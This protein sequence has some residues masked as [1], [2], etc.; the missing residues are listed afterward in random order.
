[1]RRFLESIYKYNDKTIFRMNS[2]NLLIWFLCF[3]NSKWQADAN[4]ATDYLQNQV[5]QILVE[6]CASE[7]DRNRT[8]SAI[9]KLAK[10]YNPEESIKDVVQFYN[11]N[12]EDS[13]N[14]LLFFINQLDSHEKRHIAVNTLNDLIDTDQL[15]L[16]NVLRFENFIRE[17]LEFSEV[18]DDDRKIYEQ[19][20]ITITK[21]IKKSIITTDLK[22]IVKYAN[23]SN[24]PQRIYDLIPALVQGIDINN[25][26]D[27]NRIFE[28]S[29]Q[30]PIINQLKFLRKLLTKIRNS[31]QYT[32]L[33]HIIRQ[34]KLMRYS[35][36]EDY[37]PK[38]NICLLYDIEKKI[39]SK[40]LP[41]LE[42]YDTYSIKN[43]ATNEF[44]HYSESEKCNQ[45]LCLFPNEKSQSWSF[46][47]ERNQ[48]AV[49]IVFSR[50]N[51]LSVQRS[52]IS[53]PTAKHF[54]ENDPTQ[55]NWYF[56]W[57]DDLD[58]FQIKNTYTNEFLISDDVHGTN[59]VLRRPVSL[60]TNCSH[61]NS[62]KWV[63][64]ER[65]NYSGLPNYRGFYF[66]YGCQE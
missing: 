23:N 57:G 46:P 56:V 36:R 49:F 5:N 33:F 17:K 8:V 20:L 7:I 63:L 4:Y 32:H 54:D 52:N 30:L 37:W 28:F 31:S 12:Y 53:L 29:S 13:F 35:I 59:D 61:K 64:S 11:N 47:T 38:E 16:V 50:T 65:A 15:N 45:N 3:V 25:F 60:S 40:L 26:T 27:M 34:I 51:Y 6:F 58:S 10:L 62:C 39:P 55:S 1:M 14:N 66:S 44:L 9:A 24:D 42:M 18:N 43:L 2:V 21:N 41:I 22:E 48:N 19:F